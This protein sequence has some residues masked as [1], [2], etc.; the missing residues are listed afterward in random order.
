MKTILVIEDK[1][2]VR[3]NIAEML[4]LARYQVVQ[5]KDGKQG[6]AFAR[7]A[8]PDLILCDIMMPELD[9]FGVLHIL[10]KDPDTARIPFIFLTAKVDPAHIRSGMNL[11]ADD[12]LTKPI[13]DINLL[14]A[15]ELRLKKAEQMRRDV[16][17]S[18][19]ANFLDSFRQTEEPTYSTLRY[20]KKQ[21]LYAEGDTPTNLY[22]VRSGQVKRFKT[23]ASA[24]VF[25]TAL[26]SAGDFVGLPGLV[27][28]GPHEESAEVLLDAE[29]CLIP[30]SELQTLL[31]NH[32]DI[33]VYFMRLLATELSQR[34]KRLLNLAYQPVRKR[35]AEALLLVH[36]KF[37]SQL[38]GAKGRPVKLASQNEP[39]E[40]S[41]HNRSSAMTLSRENWSQLVGASIETVIRVLSDLRAEGML[42]LSGSQI[43]L[44]NIDRLTRLRH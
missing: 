31:T 18:G 14:A 34:D 12:Y 5:A 32:P 41:G 40:P 8:R 9:G 38:D 42:E 30:Q 7:S 29:I 37:Y 28:G 35:V 39:D 33:G 15:V 3:E 13:D 6:V 11:G 21:S 26:A 23:D 16:S 27:Q 44:L 20:T 24:N 43:I 22:Y 19:L 25:I 10:T 36:R 17:Q 1:K 2:E 4:Q